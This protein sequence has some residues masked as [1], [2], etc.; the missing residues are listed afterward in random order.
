M[1]IY[2]YLPH[3]LAR[4]GVIARAAG[5]DRHE[6]AAQVRL[7]QERV[8]RAQVGP[9]EPHHLS[10]LFI[11]ELRCVQWERIAAVM[12]RGQVAVYAPWLDSRAVRCEEQRLQRLM[13]DVAEAERSG[14]AAPEISR[15]RVYRIGVR[16]VAGRSRPGVPGAVVH[17]MAASAEAAAERAWAVHGKDGG[18]Y[19]RAGCRIASVEQVLPEFGELF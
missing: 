11:A 5:L 3:E 17:L 15:H 2:E 19:R 18:L 9:A 10:E 6:V 7:A 12:D 13:A 8:K 14:V 4:L 16:T 1:L